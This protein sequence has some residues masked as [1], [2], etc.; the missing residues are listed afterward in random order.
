M[1]ALLVLLTI[2]ESLGS[3]AASKLTLVRPLIRV[4]ELVSYQLFLEDESFVAC[5]TPELPVFIT[6][7]D[8]LEVSLEVL[9]FLATYFT[10]LDDIM[11]QT[12][13]LP[14]IMDLLA[15]VRTRLLVT[16]LVY[17]GPVFPEKFVALK[18]NPT[19]RALGLP[20]VWVVF[21]FRM[22]HVIT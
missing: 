1:F 11:S 13:V 4:N 14:D 20:I 3:E 21:P 10:F 16:N 9:D 2:S 18:V 12:N 5:C 6:S 15:A 7:M 19:D 8:S 22:L 17:S